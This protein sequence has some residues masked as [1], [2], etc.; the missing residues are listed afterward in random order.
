[1]IGFI[2]PSIG[3]SSIRYTLESLLKQTHQE[4]KCW[5]GFDGKKQNQI[6]SSILVNDNRI[7][8]LYFGEK[9]GDESQHHGNAG[10]VRNEIIRN[11]GDDVDWIGFVDDDDTLSKYYVEILELEKTKFDFDCCVFRMRYDENNDKVIPPFGM[12]VIRQN[13]VGISFCINKKFMNDNQIS[14]INDNAEDFNFLKQISDIGGKIHIS[15]HIT[16]NVNGHRYYG[17]K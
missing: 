3:R 17:Q 13:F 4:W 14:F 8:Y 12:N 10:Q 11:V 6:D 16:Y 5:V 2:I 9:M 15:N 7:N 1:M